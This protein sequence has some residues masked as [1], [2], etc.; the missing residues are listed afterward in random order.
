VGKLVAQVFVQSIQGMH[1]DV[2]PFGQ[3]FD[4]AGNVDVHAIHGQT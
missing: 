3:L 1:L 2:V 4:N